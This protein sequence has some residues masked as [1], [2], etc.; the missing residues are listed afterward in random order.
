MKHQY[1][2]KHLAIIPDGNRRWAKEHGF[3]P[4]A[5]HQK[6][7]E[8]AKSLLKSIKK[9]NIKYLTLWG[10]S[11]ENW[12]K[13]PKTEVKFLIE[14]FSR[15]LK[16]SQKDLI[17][18]KIRFIHIGRKD[19]LPR[20]FVKV[21]TETEKLT[22][23]FSGWHLLIGF[24]YGGQDEIIRA[25]RKIAKLVKEGKLKIDQITPELFYNYT[26]TPNIPPPDLIVRT[27]GEQRLSG[28]YPFQG[29]YAELY[30]TKVPFPDF[31]E[32]ELEKA[33]NDY[34]R[35]HRRFGGN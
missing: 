6:G 13:R 14:L 23:K 25:T 18:H 27:S 26:D 30:F 5:G 28:L 9:F 11:T 34:N 24:D 1:P 2:L 20:R 12:I 19:R 8:R 21:I 4:M 32:A 7:A 22:L 16:D 29:V 15:F 10:L 35:R 3:P 17:E 31:T 33:I